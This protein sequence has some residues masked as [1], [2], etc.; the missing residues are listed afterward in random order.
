M[1]R[2]ERHRR[3]KNWFCKLSKTDFLIDEGCSYIWI[4]K[5]DAIQSKS[6]ETH[7]KKNLNDTKCFLKWIRRHRQAKL[8][9]LQRRFNTRD[10][11]GIVYFGTFF[12][13]AFIVVVR[14]RSV[15]IGVIKF[16]RIVFANVRFCSAI[17]R[18]FIRVSC[19]SKRLSPIWSL[20]RHFVNITLD[21][22]VNV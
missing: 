12:F 2:R 14:S 8:L 17:L 18:W 1:Q 5:G 3:K 7:K 9:H 21:E 19:C 13:V 4:W 15:D 11:D 10:V 16:Q 22:S 6:S 20:Q